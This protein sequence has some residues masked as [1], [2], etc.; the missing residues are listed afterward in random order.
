MLTRRLLLAAGAA[1][2]AAPAAAQVVT[3]LGPE[4]EQLTILS[5]GGFEMPL[6][7]LA[8]EVPTDAIAAETGPADPYRTVLNVTC[9]RRGAELILFDCGAGA[10]FL[11][12]SGQLQ[13]SLRAAGI[14]P[15]A[16]THVLFTHLHPDHFWGALDEF[17]SPLFP[18]ARWLA[19]A[20]E[21]DFWTAPKVYEQLPADRHAFA[22]GAQR[23]ARG[24]GD[25]LERLQAGG[26]W[27]PGI[28]AVE[29]AGHTP[30]HVSFAFEAGGQPVMVLGDALTHPR[31]SFA[32]PEWR[33]ASDQDADVAV[34]TRRSLL[35]RLSA[36]RTI[37]I[38]YHLPGAAGR[39]E[40]HGPAYRFTAS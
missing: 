37:A 34:A 32:Y 27:L 6:A 26:E 28:A 1:S 17:D 13:E 24:L 19:A 30:G 23:I 15:E 7:M 9:L 3:R 36:D 12:G 35:D 22:A 21:I 33:P 8:R 20:R 2:L 5:D 18:N 14:E 11:P 38:G 39:V 25:K 16:V 29:T 10:H 40:K 4:A 31:I